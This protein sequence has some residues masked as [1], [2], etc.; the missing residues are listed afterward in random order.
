MN[1]YCVNGDYLAKEQVAKCK[2]TVRWV[3]G[4][5]AGGS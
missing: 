3:G 5:D 2:H 1:T 4:R